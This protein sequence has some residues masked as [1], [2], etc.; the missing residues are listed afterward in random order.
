MEDID[1]CE[2][3]YG[4]IIYT[5]KGKEVITKPKSVVNEYIDIAQELNDNRKTL[6]FVTI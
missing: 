4:P 2:N 3:I 1:I 6:N 5:F